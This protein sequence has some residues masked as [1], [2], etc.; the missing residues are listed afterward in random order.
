MYKIQKRL[1]LNVNAKTDRVIRHRLFFTRQVNW[2]TFSEHCTNNCTNVANGHQLH[3]YK[4]CDQQVRR[5]NDNTRAPLAERHANDA[6]ETHA[7]IQDTRFDLKISSQ[8]V[9]RTRIDRKILA[10]K[11][12]TSVFS[13]GRTTSS[14]RRGRGGTDFFSTN[15]G[16]E[17]WPKDM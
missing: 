7:Y 8:N 2:N 3:V 13:G 6:D 15:V 5:K 16:P 10:S 9:L 11:N 4:L 12:E 17:T 1:W 14:W